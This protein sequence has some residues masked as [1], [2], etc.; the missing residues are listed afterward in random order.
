MRS[1]RPLRRAEPPGN[2]FLAAHT[3]PR[4]LP[5]AVRKLLWDDPETA[6]A[7]DRRMK[8]L[9]DRYWANLRGRTRNYPELYAAHPE[10]TIPSIWLKELV[11][12]LYDACGVLQ[13]VCSLA[14]ISV[15]MLKEWQQQDSAFREQWNQAHLTFTSRIEERM[16]GRARGN[17]AKDKSSAF[18]AVVMLNAKRPQEYRPNAPLPPPDMPT[19]FALVD[20][21]NPYLALRAGAAPGPVRPDQLPPPGDHVQIDSPRVVEGES[22]LV[23]DDDEEEPE[24]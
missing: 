16:I 10:M 2:P 3:P 6:E 5:E 4:A 12:M 22:R 19:E 1:P 11:I 15:K 24:E 8:F 9:Y 14:G 17:D 23:D 21:E 7:I 20:V 13:R 18:A